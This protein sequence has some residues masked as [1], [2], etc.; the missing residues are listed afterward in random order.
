MDGLGRLAGWRYLFLLEG[1]PPIILSV[2]AYFGLPDYPQTAKMLDQE[3]RD[4]IL[5]RLAAT[6]P[7]GKKGHWDFK[8]LKVYFSDPTAYS[9]AIYWICHGIGGF[10][11]SYALPTVIY[12]LG[13]TTT[14]LSQLMN[15]VFLPTSYR[16]YLLLILFSH[17]ILRVSFFSI[18]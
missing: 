10:G 8:T 2:V 4:F 17:P 12:Q 13:F 7:S 3:E 14:S 9:F 6:A 5:N 1:L 16:V 11:I 15:M 18:P